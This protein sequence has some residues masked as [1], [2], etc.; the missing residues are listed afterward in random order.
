[1][2]LE[3]RHITLKTGNEKILQL[4]K[5]LDFSLLDF[6][7]W[8]A[9]DILSNTLRGILAE[10]IVATALEIDIKQP[11]KEWDAFDLTTKSNIKVEVKSSAYIQTW[12]QVKFSSISFGCGPTK[13]WNY[14]IDKRSDVLKR[15][16]DVYVFCLLKYQDKSNINPLNTDHW[17]FYIIS[18]TELENKIKS[19]KKISLSALN[20]LCTP[21]NY[22]EIQKNV[23]LKNIQNLV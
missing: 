16:A 23:E 10:F 3:N 2:N 9:S 19:Q 5:E 14:E 8:S 13:E 4:G 18:N 1:M 6:W 7:K 11:R 20:K 22:S 21:V 17:E 12:E 15:H